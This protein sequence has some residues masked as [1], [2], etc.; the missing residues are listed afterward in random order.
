MYKSM[1]IASAAWSNIDAWCRA[2]DLRHL[3]TGWRLVGCRTVIRTDGGI[4]RGLHVGAAIGPGPLAVAT[5]FKFSPDVAYQQGELDRLMIARPEWTLVAEGH[6][7]P[8]LMPHPSLQDVRM[9]C[10]MGRDPGYR[11]PHA[12]M[13]IVIATVDGDRVILRGFSV[14]STPTGPV[15]SEFDI[16]VPQVTNNVVSREVRASVEPASGHVANLL[17]SQLRRFL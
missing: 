16:L 8:A 11:M 1:T 10:A 7:H 5:K 17:A 2:A 12:V 4:V 3:E 14:G 13:P 6:L 9:A 15:V